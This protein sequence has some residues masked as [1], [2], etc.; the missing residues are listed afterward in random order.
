MGVWGLFRLGVRMG[1]SGLGP[2]SL[3]SKE[4]YQDPS[5]P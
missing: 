2:G 5:V 4:I 3:R 1:G